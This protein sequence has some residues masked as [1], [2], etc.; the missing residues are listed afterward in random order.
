MLQI[1]ND[2]SQVFALTSAVTLIIFTTFFV[3]L[4]QMGV[5]S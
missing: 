1:R 5:A 4:L 3:L 2:L